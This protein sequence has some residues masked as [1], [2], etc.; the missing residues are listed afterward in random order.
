MLAI[1]LSWFW[2]HSFC[3][4]LLNQ[5]LCVRYFTQY[6][7]GSFG[8]WSVIIAD[9]MCWIFYWVYLV[10]IWYWTLIY[11]IWVLTSDSSRK[12]VLAILQNK[13][14][15]QSVIDQLW[16]QTLCVGYFTKWFWG[17]L[18][19]WPVMKADILCQLFNTVDFG[20]IW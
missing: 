13:F 2:V 7:M 4:Q 15:V 19:N 1:L 17:K 10:Y 20:F 6:I 3:D 9:S 12:Y 11:V 18:G 14:G 8:N 16:K 5:T